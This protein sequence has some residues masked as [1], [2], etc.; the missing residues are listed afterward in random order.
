MNKVIKVGGFEISEFRLFHA[1]SLQF[2]PHVTLIAG[3]NGTAKS[4]LLGM[5]AQPFSFGVVRGTTAGDS[6]HSTYTKNYHG[7]E[8]LTFRDLSGKLFMYDCDD[9][10]RLSEKYDFGKDYQY[11]TKLILPATEVTTLPENCLLTKSRDRKK[12]EKITGMRFVTGPGASHKPG[13]GNFPHPVIY[14]GLNRLWPLAATEK[15]TFSGDAISAED[16][17]WYVSKYNE[18]LCLDENDNNAKYMDTKEK[19][20]FITPE[21]SNYDGESCSAGQDNLS[22]LLTAILSFR[23]LKANLGDKYRGGLFLIDELDATLHAFSQDKLLELLCD[24]SNELGLQVIATTHSLRLLEKAYQSSLK[25]KIKVLYLANENSGIVERTFSTFQE[26]S[27]HLKV[28]STPPSTRKQRKVS[29]IVEDKAGELLFK[30]ICGSKLRNFIS[31]GNTTSFGAGDLKNLGILSEKLPA[32]QDVI[33]VPDGDMVK[34]WTNPP[35]NLLALPGGKRPETLAY[36]HL[37]S[38]NDSDPFWRSISTTYTRQYAI[39]SKEGQS[40]QTGDNKDWVKKWYT[41]QSK[42]WGQGNKKMFKSWVQ[43]NKADCLNFCK[44]FISLLRGRYK[45]D[46]PKDVITRTLA[47]FK[48]S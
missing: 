44:K 41:D 12:G 18:I 25:N 11:K 34:T 45:G 48:D 6:D 31:V 38:M 36:R 10:F 35:K 19:R 13:E 4:T 43:A 17:R 42:H 32:L 46:I 7:L 2:G 15:C 9:V 20:K 5:L 47:E 1:I 29:V 28:E 27:D 14:L 8:L 24:V 26:I 22:Q 16:R 33:L 39:T 21:S 40:L 30:Q 3:Q 37:Y 23:G